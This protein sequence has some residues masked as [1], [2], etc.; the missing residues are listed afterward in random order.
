MKEAPHHAI[1]RH[2][3]LSPH[4]RRSDRKKWIHP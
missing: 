2:P 1:I 3:H 4:Y